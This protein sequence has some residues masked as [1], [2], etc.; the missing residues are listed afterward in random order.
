MPVVFIYFSWSPYICDKL[1]KKKKKNNNIENLSLFIVTIFKYF[2]Q[3]ESQ[4]EVLVTQTS[5]SLIRV[6][7]DGSAFKIL[8]LLHHS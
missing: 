5:Y 3:A 4:S 2:S 1:L 6:Q 8:G 7:P